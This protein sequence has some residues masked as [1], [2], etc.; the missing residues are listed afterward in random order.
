[1]SKLI[2]ILLT[3]LMF[4]AVGVVFLSKGLKQ[5]GEL[6]QVS[7]PEIARLISRGL[8]NPNI[9]LG[10]MFEAI[11]FAGLL[12]LLSKR[13]VSVVWP[14]T[15]LG[16]VV[17]TSAA[18]LF[19]QEH[20]SSLRWAGVSLIVLGAALITLSDRAKPAVAQPEPTPPASGQSRL[21]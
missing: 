19:L 1:M 20:V 12:Y 8:T 18:K 13:D 2:F 17:T 10:V 4:E 21:D 6:R 3:A 7:V 15:A 5:I 14:L 9:L 16:F 11:F